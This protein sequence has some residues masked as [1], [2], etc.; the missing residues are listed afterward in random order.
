[1]IG[2]L[3]PPQG[4][5]LVAVEQSD[6]RLNATAK[7]SHHGIPLF[8]RDRQLTDPIRKQREFADR[9]QLF[10]SRTLRQ[11]QSKRSLLKELEKSVPTGWYS[12]IK[13]SHLSRWS[14]RFSDG[15]LFR[16]DQPLDLDSTNLKKTVDVLA[17][18]AYFYCESFAR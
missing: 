2:F 3:H 15:V 10:L 9:R 13:R 16:H 18:A 1:V 8:V 11:R 6:G 17:G 14:F 7:A 5:L 4:G 12:E